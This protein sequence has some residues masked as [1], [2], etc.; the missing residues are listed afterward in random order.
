MPS[1]LALLSYTALTCDDAVAREV[2]QD[3]H[4]KGYLIPKGA[5]VMANNWAIS[6]DE[7]EY[8]EPEV[9]RPERFLDA[10]GTALRTD[11]L[12]PMKYAFGFGHRTCPGRFLADSL[13]FSHFAH[14]LA[15]FD[16]ALPVKAE[17]AKRA[18][19]SKMTIKSC[20]AAWCVFRSLLGWRRGVLIRSAGAAGS[21]TC[22]SRS[23]RA[24][25]LPRRFSTSISLRRRR[26]APRTVTDRRRPRPLDCVSSMFPTTVS[27][28]KYL[29]RVLPRLGA[30]HLLTCGC[31]EIVST[32]IMTMEYLRVLVYG[33]RC[34]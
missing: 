20:G 16:V 1:P 8:P 6:R 26:T 2:T 34:D 19:D 18:A 13:L 24:R 10:A 28:C 4:Y 32:T 27:T 25:R 5:T 30:R 14:V 21:R 7:S 15:A 22:T 23:R 3:D 33:G 12:Q 31:H 29:T 9:F 17:K 11:I